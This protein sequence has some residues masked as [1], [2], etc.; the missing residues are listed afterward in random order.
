MAITFVNKGTWAAGTTSISPGIPASMQA[1]D[2]MILQV[3]TCNQAVTTPSGWTQ[4]TTSP[5]ST[6]TANTAG[7]TR[8][9]VYYRWWQSGDAA[10]TVAVTG[11]TVTNGIIVGY[12]GVDPT[13]PFDGVTPVATTKA[14]ASTTLTMTGLTT[15]TNNALIHWAV[16]R[17]QDLNSTTAVTA[18][19]NA[20]LTGITETHDQVVSTGVGGGIWTGRGFKTTAGA[21]GDLTITQTS[22][23]AVGITFALRPAPNNYSL[24]AQG[25]SYTVTGG[26]ANID[27][28]G[29]TP[30]RISTTVW[31]QDTL[32]TN[33]TPGAKAITVPADAQAVVIHAHNGCTATNQTLTISSDFTGTFTVIDSGEQ[34]N[35]SVGYAVVTSTGSKNLTLTWSAT[36]LEGPTVYISFIKNINTADW[37][38]DADVAG[39]TSGGTARTIVFTTNTSDLLLVVND[40]DAAT[41]TTISGF[42]SIATTGT[43]YSQP[44][45]L[46]SCN[47]P[48]SSTTS[49]TGTSTVYDVLS[50]ISIKYGVTVNGY[51]LTANGGAYSLTGSNVTIKRS[52]QL[53]ASGGSY[54][55]TGQQAIITWSAGLQAY[56]LTCLGGSYSIGGS[57]GS[58]S[59]NRRLT[60]TG[61]NYTQTGANATLL[62]SKRIV[63]SG[64]SY[65]LTGQSASILR[66]KRIIASGGSYTVLGSSASIF[67]SRVLTAQGGSY[68]ITGQNAVIT[69][70]L[71]P[72]AYSLVC[73]GGSY[74]VTGSQATV[75][76][77]KRLTT[78]GG[79]YTVSGGQAVIMK[80][81][82]LQGSGG[83]YTIT[84][85]SAAI[86]RNRTLIAQGG[87]YQYTGQ[88]IT[89]LKTGQYWP[90]PSEVL[91][92][93]MYGPTGVEYTGT[94]DIGKK[95][96]I[97]INTGNIVMVLDGKKVMSL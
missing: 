39:T 69:Y 88:Q 49:V 36:M 22:S 41:P 53:V 76:R 30:I 71:G 13:T 34:N 47:A 12:R 24:I 97:D 10:P 55:I 15:A 57:S 64:G 44:T 83:S 61:G 29:L 68:T 74:S 4:A 19:T 94:L 79:S 25:G 43:T 1:G 87:T 28:V 54:T 92:G 32:G 37:V 72:N 95:F 91:L 33:G 73:L 8:I 63:A 84:G 3:H 81:K 16:A 38:R 17:D 11:G 96:R 23:I 62:R 6:G 40:N 42:T 78:Q 52:K 60:S 80:S 89:I 56:T 82:Y 75:N 27:Y 70:A 65:T 90:M 46:Q 18:F 51:T 50:G 48:G 21:T 66:S 5:V 2:F 35:C 86:S 20:N 59:R 31:E 58:I 77:N 93:V 14:T 85:A 45:R 26:S 9:S 7:G 67:R